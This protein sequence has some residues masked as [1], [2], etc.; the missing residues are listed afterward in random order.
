M[1]AIAI[2]AVPSFGRLERCC[3]ASLILFT[4]DK[5]L[6]AQLRCLRDHAGAVDRAVA[7]R[8]AASA[9]QEQAHL[10]RAAIARMPAQYRKPHGVL[11]FA[12]TA[13]SEVIAD[14]GINEK[15][16]RGVEL[17]VAR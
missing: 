9:Q 16:R 7:L 14:A 4:A 1:A 10:K 12:Q 6:I 17:S 2:P 13:L 15:V 11:I 3:A 8:L 5:N